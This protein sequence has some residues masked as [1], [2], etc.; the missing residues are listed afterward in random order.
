MYWK[1][2]RIT[3]PAER[4]WLEYVDVCVEKALITLE[5]GDTDR[6]GF[7]VRELM[8]NAMTASENLST[9]EPAVIEV[10]LAGTDEWIEIRVT[11]QGPGL[12]EGWETRISAPSS[13]V[14]FTAASGRGLYLVREMVDEMS[15][16]RTPDGRHVF[17]I[18]KRKGPPHAESE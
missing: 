13:P 15:S 9:D 3:V 7:A 6:L 5:T 16:G 11:D 2:T 4:R 8:I 18:R 10:E 1:N 12:T 17:C 14:F